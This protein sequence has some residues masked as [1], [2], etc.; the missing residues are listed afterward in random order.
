MKRSIEGR[1]KKEATQRQQ[2]AGKHEDG[3]VAGR[4][5]TDMDSPPRLSYSV[6]RP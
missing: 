6:D 5:A 3:G 1:I 2:E 4:V